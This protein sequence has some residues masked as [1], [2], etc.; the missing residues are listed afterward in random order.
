MKLIACEIQKKL[1]YL[2]PSEQRFLELGAVL[3]CFI[4]LGGVGDIL[5]LAG[6][7]ID[8]RRLTAFA[9]KNFKKI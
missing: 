6:D 9:K 3:D 1:C 7:V 2:V 4:C 8:K 5:I